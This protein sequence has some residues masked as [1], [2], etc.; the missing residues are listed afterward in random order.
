MAGSPVR[1]PTV[2]GIPALR[3]GASVG[4][5]TALYGGTGWI[6]GQ[7]HDYDREYAVNLVQLGAFLEATQ[8]AVATAADLE[9]DSPTRRK[10]L[11]RLQGEITKR[12]RSTCCAAASSTAPTPWTS[13][14]HPV[15]RQPQGRRA[16]HRQPL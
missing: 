2:S 8:P 7:W 3:A 13:S 4:E 11:A 12:G 10:F 1:T 16:L 9:H 14:R 6:L 15:P 5:P